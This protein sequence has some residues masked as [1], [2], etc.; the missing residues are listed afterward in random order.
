MDFADQGRPLQLSDFMPYL[1][2]ILIIGAIAAA[3]VYYRRRNDLTQPC[4]DSQKLFREL[5]LAHD[6]D[7]AAQKLLGQLADAF[8]LA[9]PAEV[10]VRPSVFTA[11]QLPDHLR[12]EAARIAEL[13]ERLF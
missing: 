12:A 2:G 1:I 3:I 9:Q 10:F 11:E 5:C 6:L 13:H 7:R 8:H 4:T